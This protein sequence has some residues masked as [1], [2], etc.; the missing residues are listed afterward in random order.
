MKVI[1]SI[2]TELSPGFHEAGMAPEE[3]FRRNI[4]GEGRNGAVGLEYQLAAFARNRLKAVFFVE[5]LSA[6]RTGEAFLAR[7]L[8]AVRDGGCEAQLHAH[9]EWLDDERRDFHEY[10]EAGQAALLKR[11]L[12]AFAAAGVHDVCAFRAGNFGADNATLRAAAAAGLSWDSSYNPAALASVEPDGACRI[13]APVQLSLPTRIDG[14]AEAPVAAFASGA[15]MR[16]VQLCAIS[17]AEMRAALYAAQRRGDPLFVIVLHS[18]ELLNVQRTRINPLY[19]RRFKRLCAFL[20]A[21]RD[22]FP[23]AGFAD[24]KDIPL[25]APTAQAGLAPLRGSALH[26]AARYAEQALSRA[27]FDPV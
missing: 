21:H 26:A 5:A 22:R 27:I 3:N 16:P 4:L 11:G 24:I 10:D 1:L 9:A 17:F 19:V 12:D 18:F 23:T 20:A 15:K 13:E 6:S 14:V 25:S 2:D 7:T 8:K